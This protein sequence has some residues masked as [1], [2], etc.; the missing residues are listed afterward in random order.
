MG[1]SISDADRELIELAGKAIGCVHIDD[2]KHIGIELVTADDA[3]APFWMVDGKHCSHWNPLDNDGDALR[4]AVKLWLVVDP[5]GNG[6]PTG[7]EVKTLNGITVFE[8]L[9][10]DADAAVRRAIVRAAGLTDG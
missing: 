8:P 9:G 7:A 5:G 2:A 10:D 1:N 6:W 3:W 4:L